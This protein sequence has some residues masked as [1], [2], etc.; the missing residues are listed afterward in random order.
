MVFIARPVSLPGRH[1]TS[2]D[3]ISPGFRCLSA[4]RAWRDALLNSSEP[5]KRMRRGLKAASRNRGKTV[6]TWKYGGGDSDW[7]KT[8]GHLT[9]RTCVVLK[10][11]FKLS[12]LM[13]TLSLTPWRLGA[14]ASAIGILSA[15]QDLMIVAQLALKA[16][17]WMLALRC[18][19]DPYSRV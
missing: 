6:V 5:Q 10:K 13:L 2:M 15:R 12:T 3:L 4:Q 8:S 18:F 9:F 16:G 7:S 1:T 17:S 19:R 14:I 11:C